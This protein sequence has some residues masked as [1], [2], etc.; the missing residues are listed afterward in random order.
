MNCGEVSLDKLYYGKGDCSIQGNISSITINYRGAIFITSKVPHRYY[1]K[2]K[3]NVLEIN[4]L[5]DTHSL[6]ELF[7]YIGEFRILS[8]RANDLQGENVSISVNRVMDYT[9]LLTTNSEDLTTKSEDLKVGYVYGRKFK[10]TMMNPVV[11]EN[12]KT[13][14]AKKDL[15]LSGTQYSGDFHMHNNGVIMTGRIHTKDS[16]ILEIR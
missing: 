6:T 8:A 3:N 5:F 12:L 10:K 9:E 14:D 11:T 16:K 15:Y 13:Q 4:T 7:S 2:Q 1:I